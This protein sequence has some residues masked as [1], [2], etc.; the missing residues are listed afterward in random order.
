MLDLWSRVVPT[1]PQSDLADVAVRHHEYELQIGASPIG[2]Y[3]SLGDSANLAMTARH[4]DEL[5][6]RGPIG[7]GQL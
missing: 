7:S 1:L 5:L 3:A 2:W 6:E 4:L